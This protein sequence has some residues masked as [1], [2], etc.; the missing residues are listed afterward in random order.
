MSEISYSKILTISIPTF[1]RGILVRELLENITGQ[2]SKHKLENKIEVQITNNASSDNTEPIIQSYSSKHNYIF[3]T[4]NETN[5]GLG[6]NVL[7]CMFL[8]NGKYCLLLGDDDRLK[9][10]SLPQLIAFLE[11]NP[12]TGLLIDTANNKK[13]KV[14]KPT[15]LNLVQMLERYYY[16]MGN[17]G[18]FVVLSS[19]IKE[20]YENRNFKGIS[21]SWPQTQFMIMSSYKHPEKKIQ[22][23]NFNLVGES[24][25]TNIT[26]YNSYYLWKVAY[27]E[28]V[29]DIENIRQGVSNEVVRAAKKYFSN[30]AIQNFYNI[31]QCG[32]FIDDAET[33]VKTRKHILSH[34][35]HFSFKEKIL[36]NIIVMVLWLPDSLSKK[37]SNLFIYLTRGSKGLEKKNNFVKHEK[38][39]MELIKSKKETIIRDFSY[40]GAAD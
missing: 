11:E 24:E 20:N 10:D 29:V 18:V 4:K 2:V 35:T 25:H 14:N 3:Y 16:F 8:A 17:A 30:H 23:D 22:L 5:I 15:Q 39:K 38:K 19:Y 33:K 6:P 9:P 32:V 12:D 34:L 31:L 37:F 27:Y 13:D 40:E 21:F 28:L 36:L 1:N 26:L 7:K